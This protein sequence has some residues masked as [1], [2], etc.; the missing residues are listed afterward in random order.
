MNIMKYLQLFFCCCC[1]VF[2]VTTVVVVVVVVD[3]DD[4][5]SFGLSLEFVWKRRDFKENC[6][7]RL[8]IQTDFH[9]LRGYPTKAPGHKRWP[10]RRSG[11]LREVS[12]KVTISTLKTTAS[13]TRSHL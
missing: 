8:Y 2:A 9:Y 11:R 4:A 6:L 12:Y 1:F 13:C 10:A 7:V 5:L 3:D